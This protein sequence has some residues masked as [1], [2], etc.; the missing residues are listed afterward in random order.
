[1]ILIRALVLECL[2]NNVR[3]FTRYIRSKDNVTSDLLSRLHIEDFKKLSST[4]DAEPTAIP[5]SMWPI[6]KCWKDN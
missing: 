4:W 3:V 6:Y 5:C 1:M 2:Y